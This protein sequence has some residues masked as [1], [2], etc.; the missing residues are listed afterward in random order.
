M[1][2]S[3]KIELVQGQLDAYNS[4]DIEK[5]CSYYHP[6]VRAYRIGESKPFIQGIDQ[7][8]ASYAEKFKKTPDLHCKLKSRIILKGRVLDEESVTPSGSHV[9]AIYDFKDDLIHE[10]Y[11]VY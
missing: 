1:N 11:F 6:E 8:Q 7:F 2:E 3:K 9:V 4:L 5:F 10:I